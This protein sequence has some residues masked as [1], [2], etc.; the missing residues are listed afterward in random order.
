[1][2]ILQCLSAVFERRSS[3]II[4]ASNIA[5]ARIFPLTASKTFT[6][7]ITYTRRGWGDGRV[8]TAEWL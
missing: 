2:M 4:V 7:D 6:D 3:D 1:M 5:A 8:Y